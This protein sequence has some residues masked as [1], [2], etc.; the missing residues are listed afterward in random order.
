MVKLLQKLV[1]VQGDKVP[2]I[3]LISNNKGHGTKSVTFNIFNLLQ[4]FP[5]AAEA[6]FLV[7]KN[8][9]TL[10]LHYHIRHYRIMVRRI[11]IHNRV[12]DNL[13]S[14]HLNTL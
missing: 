3:N 1:G 5:L 9:R 2:L 12:A 14:V 10:I 6:F 8:Q 7:R 11:H 13:I 4:Y